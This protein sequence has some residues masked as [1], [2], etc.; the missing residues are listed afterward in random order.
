MPSILVD[1]D[2]IILDT[3][4]PNLK[5]II[6]VPEKIKKFSPGLVLVV[7]NSAYEKISSFSPGKK[8]VEYLNNPEFVN[9]IKN[10]CYVYYSEK[11]DVCVLLD[12]C[13]SILQEILPAIL[14]G[15]PQ[16]TIIWLSLGLD[17]VS[18]LNMCISNG[19]GDPY[20]TKTTPMFTDIPES[21]AL[22]RRNVPKEPISPTMIKNKAKHA[23]EQYKKGDGCELYAQLSDRS[24]NFLRKASDM[25]ITISKNGKE[26]QKELTGELYVKDV[27]LNKGKMVYV[28]DID[29]DSVESGDQENVDV[30]PTRYNFHSHPRQAYVNHSVTKAWPSSTDYVGYKTLGANT[31]FH[32]VAA[33]EG[34]YIMSFTPYWGPNLNK[35]SNNYIENKFDID[36]REKYTPEEYVEKVN[37]ILYK[38]HPIYNVMYYP[39]DNAGEIFK[40]SYPPLGMSCPATQKTADVYKK[41]H[42]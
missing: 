28:I 33:I 37:S 2:K 9:S 25:G 19:F 20:V 6:E 32:C 23:I 41:V 36:H 34:V 39:W 27:I 13:L 30:S 38:G 21:L 11:K 7:T 35:I 8:R 42:K 12:K 1:Y 15:F 29:E 17:D 3:N 5:K 31:I 16:T 14:S 4:L 10:S 18:L 24:V 22:V 26:I 40:V